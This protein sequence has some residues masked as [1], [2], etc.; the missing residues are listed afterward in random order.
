LFNSFIGWIFLGM[1]AMLQL[2]GGLAMK[3]VITIKV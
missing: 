2:I 1:I 3:K